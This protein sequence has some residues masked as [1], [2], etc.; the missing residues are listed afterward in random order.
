MAFKSCEGGIVM[1]NSS[2]VVGNVF[3]MTGPIVGLN[4]N[5]VKGDAI[6]AGPGR[7]T[8]NGTHATGTVYAHSI[9]NSDAVI[10]TRIT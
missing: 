10:K 7:E 4:S 5:M 6:S 1:E 2:Q 9:S 3:S 8:V